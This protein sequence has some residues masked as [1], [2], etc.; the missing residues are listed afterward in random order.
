MLGISVSVKLLPLLF[1]PLLF[2]YFLKT[3]THNLE[4]SSALNLKKLVLYYILIGFTVLVSFLPFISSE[5][6]T[7]FSTSIALWFQKF[8]F[9]A[10]I[11]Y[12]IRWLGFQLKGYNIIATAG[13]ILPAVILLII[14]GLS[15]FRKNNS[16]QKLLT[17]MLLG[18]S[19][20]FFL[21]TTVHP[22]Y[23]A[24]P[25]LFGV[26][27]K[28]RFALVWSFLVILSYSAYAKAG[29]QENYWLVAFEYIFVLGVLSIE[30]YKPRLSF[31][32]LNNI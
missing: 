28:F 2:N 5:F 23:L 19:V 31:R 32:L 8:E 15:F 9:N 24:T 25:L 3:K 22:W 30:L 10:S 21:S 7:N 16:I 13:K 27:T 11:Y 14:L 6:F 26:F 17:T 4:E 18:V 12:I 20:Y 29:F 1:L